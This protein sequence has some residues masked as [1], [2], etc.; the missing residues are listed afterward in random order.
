MAASPI[1]QVSIGGGPWLST[2]DGVDV[3]PSTTIS[4]RLE[5][6]SE[7]YE[8]YLEVVGTDELSTAPSLLH[9]DPVT[10]LVDTTT[11]VVEYTSPSTVG[12][13]LNFRSRVRTDAGPTLTTNFATYVPTAEGR[14]VGAFG[15]TLE[16]NPAFGW[17]SIVNPV[18]RNSGGFTAGG[19]LTGS[20]TDQTVSYIRGI[21]SMNPAFAADGLFVKLE[22]PTY[23]TEPYN[24]LFDGDYGYLIEANILEGVTS[25]VVRKFHL[26]SPTSWELS[27]SVDITPVLDANRFSDMAQ[28]GTYLFV[29]TWDWENVVIIRKSNMAIV[30]WAYVEDYTAVSVASDGAG[31]FYVNAAGSDSRIFKF[32]VSDCLGQPPSTVTSSVY[33]V[34]PNI[35]SFLRYGGGK[36][37]FV[38]N[39]RYVDR[40]DPST[41]LLEDTWDAGGSWQI[42]YADYLLDSVWA[43][44][45]HG[46]SSRVSRIIP[47]DMSSVGIHISI[48]TP[49]GC[50]VG[51]SATGNDAI[52]VGSATS[53][54]IAWLNPVTNTEI[55][56]V[57]PT[58]HQHHY[59]LLAARGN[60]VYACSTLFSYSESTT[61]I[62][63]LSLPDSVA[64]ADIVFPLHLKY[65]YVDKLLGVPLPTGTL[66]DAGVLWYSLTD[67][68]WYADAP[69]GDISGFP[70]VNVTGL[71][72]Y[73]ISATGPTI[74]NQV[75]AWNATLWR[76]EPRIFSLSGT[77][78][79]DLSGTYP[80]PSVVALRGQ[81][82]SAATPTNTQVMTYVGI[83]PTGVWTPQTPSGGGGP[84]TLSFPSSS[85]CYIGAPVVLRDIGGTLTAFPASYTGEE[86]NVFRTERSNVY[87]IDPA[88][89][90]PT[91]AYPLDACPL[92]TQEG[93][94]CSSFVIA[95]ASG[96]NLRIRKVNVS[97][98]YTFTQDTPLDIAC[99]NEPSLISVCCVAP[100][101]IV[102]ST[103]NTNPTAFVAYVDGTI[104]K[105]V[106]VDLSTNPPTASAAVNF[107]DHPYD[108]NIDSLS[109]SNTW[110]NRNPSPYH[111]EYAPIVCWGLEGDTVIWGRLAWWNGSTI[112]LASYSGEVVKHNGTGITENVT[113]GTITTWAQSGDGRLY[114]TFGA[115]GRWTFG[116]HWYYS[117]PNDARFLND[118]RTTRWDGPAVGAGTPGFVVDPTLAR[119]GEGCYVTGDLAVSLVW[120]SREGYEDCTYTCVAD[121]AGLNVSSR[122]PKMMYDPAGDIMGHSQSS[123]WTLKVRLRS[124]TCRRITD[125]TFA[126]GAANMETWDETVPTS[127]YNRICIGVGYIRDGEVSVGMTP[128]FST[129]GVAYYLYDPIAQGGTTPDLYHASITGTAPTMT[130]SGMTGMTPDIVG[131]II[132]IQNSASNDGYFKVSAYL[133]SSSIQ[134]TNASGV[135]PD[136]NNGHIEWHMGPVPGDEKQRIVPVRLS[137]ERFGLVFFARLTETG[138]PILAMTTGA[139]ANDHMAVGVCTSTSAPGT[140]T[141]LPYGPVL[142]GFTGLTPGEWLAPTSAN[143]GTLVANVHPT[144]S[145]RTGISISATQ[146]LYLPPSRSC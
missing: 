71:R 114:G 132:R 40:I 103:T 79:G 14:R 97:S 106:R 25:K 28:D 13:A 93:R 90:A 146:V 140:V 128:V 41:M 77:A 108:G 21:A 47:T 48:S 141:V 7:S 31:S 39:S 46:A 11:T 118:D 76:W 116:T 115:T 121:R 10:H 123:N 55:G 84:S 3:T 33:C 64:P 101:R 42:I 112:Q 26:A 30:G 126:F 62:T 74:D 51:K 122:P 81:S 136:G 12:H 111:F 22:V 58:I 4:I 92:E 104:G 1:C 80:S 67:N 38:R 89:T 78:S 83:Y 43:T 63:Y 70:F 88:P 85:T 94:L 109:V 65:S 44:C 2:L 131:A 145:K 125:S 24:L 56:H 75:L 49:S 96:T 15:E 105:L 9:V 110:I 59:A 50:C 124:T 23:Y 54:A 68:A 129:S 99:T 86:Q 119:Y 5:T 29:T 100:V 130:L 127:H 27:G 120:G 45:S 16:G 19:D 117:S 36:L 143:G 72:G 144:A 113:H 60:Y 138:A 139:I 135:G 6:S 137:D 61:G 142:L 35:G 52:F 91:K 95:H 34:V 69:Y 17:A 32:S 87:T 20:S 57:E 82:I 18:I 133:S 107:N 53:A 73:P 37:W 66:P 8:W 98:D 102:G 134:Y